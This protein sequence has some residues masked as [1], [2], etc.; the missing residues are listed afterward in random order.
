MRIKG[1]NE[2]KKTDLIT[3]LVITV[4]VGVTMPIVC[5]VYFIE[6]ETAPQLCTLSC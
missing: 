4:S 1:K 3:N 5:Q 6:E 2:K